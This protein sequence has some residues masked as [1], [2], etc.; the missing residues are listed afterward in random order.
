MYIAR[1][2]VSEAEIL[3]QE[4]GLDAQVAKE[5]VLDKLFRPEARQFQGER[6]HNGSL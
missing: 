6:K 2:L 3:S 1:L 4:D 5:D